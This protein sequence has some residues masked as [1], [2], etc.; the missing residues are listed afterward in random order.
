MVDLAFVNLPMGS[1]DSV[2]INVTEIAAMRR[3]TVVAYTYEEWTEITLKN[4]KTF[5]CKIKKADV[6]DKIKKA[7]EASGEKELTWTV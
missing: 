6:V 7:L 3:H 5:D 4:G 1:M 2:D